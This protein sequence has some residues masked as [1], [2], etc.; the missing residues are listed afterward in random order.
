[1]P[2]ALP[3][4]SIDAFLDEGLEQT[5]SFKDAM[6]QNNILL[7]KVFVQNQDG[8]ELLNKWRDSL[9]MTPTLDQDSTVMAAGLNEGEKRFIRNIITAIQSVEQEL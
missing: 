9:I 4:N 2:E 1:M 7:H 8:V 6:E 3:E 5:N